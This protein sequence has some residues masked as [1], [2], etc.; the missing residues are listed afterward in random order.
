MGG[1]C[2]ERS[3]VGGAECHCA[4]RGIL[5]A[6]LHHTAQH[7]GSPT[8]SVAAYARAEYRLLGAT[9]PGQHGRVSAAGAP[10]APDPD[11]PDGS[12]GRPQ[13]GGANSSARGPPTGK[14]PA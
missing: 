8:L 11:F 2:A 10:A 6:K 9:A 1:A 7:S 3:T 13:P 4:G 14:N 5:A 12:G